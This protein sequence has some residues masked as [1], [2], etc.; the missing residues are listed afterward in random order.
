MDEIP[1]KPGNRSIDNKI[2]EN[3][4]GRDKNKL[5]NNIFTKSLLVTDF[6]K[7]QE[8]LKFVSWIGGG[9]SLLGGG[10]ARLKGQ[11]HAIMTKEFTM[12]LIKIMN[13]SLLG[14]ATARHFQCKQGKANRWLL[15]KR[16]SISRKLTSE[17][18]NT[19]GQVLV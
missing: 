4:N 2:K 8:Q 5:A 3:R 10:L 17:Y 13:I 16:K 12:Y 19:D 14:V 6:N 15:W 1:L 11:C 7:K 9:A 18:A